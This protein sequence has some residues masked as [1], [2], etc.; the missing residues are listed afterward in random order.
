MRRIH[1]ITQKELVDTEKIKDSTAVVID[2]LLATSTIAFAL[3]KGIKSVT[4]VKSPDEGFSILKQNPKN[5]LLMGES[6]GNYIEGME[7]PD[8]L[9]FDDE[10][11]ARKDSLILLTTNG[12]VGIENASSAINLYTSSLLNGHV[13]AKELHDNTGDS[14]IAIVCAGNHGRFSME[15]FIGAGQLIHHLLSIGD[16]YSYSLADS[17]IAA[18]ECYKAAKADQF[19]LLHS[20]ETSQLLHTLGFHHAIN[21]IVDHIEKVDIISKM[22]NGKIINISKK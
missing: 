9:L 10:K 14:S 3:N 12:T 18:L 16:A 22:E 6:K 17:S 19:S 20:L 15:D 8:P 4:T 13:I 1:V 5:N 2:V 11:H 7:Y 21:L